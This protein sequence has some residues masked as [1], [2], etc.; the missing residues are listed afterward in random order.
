MVLQ[1]SVATLLEN[2][3]KVFVLYVDVRKAFDSV[4]IDGLFHRLYALGVT[5]K[6]WIILYGTYVDFKCRVCVSDKVSAWYPMSC[7]IHRLGYLSLIKYTAFIDSL[8]RELDNSG[9]CATIY[10]IHVSPLGYADDIASASVSKSKIDNVL[11]IAGK[12]S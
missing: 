12:L 10:G 3:P 5:G 7:G 1:E 9:A 6:T 2:N 4:W 11:R 8:I